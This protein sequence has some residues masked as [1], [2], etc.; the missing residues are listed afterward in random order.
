[1]LTQR[2][3]L[4]GAVLLL[5]LLAG[6]FV[7][8]LVNVLRDWS[9]AEPFPQTLLVLPSL[10]LIPLVGFVVQNNP[11]APLCCV[12]ILL[13]LRGYLPANGAPLVYSYLVA[14]FLHVILLFQL[15]DWPVL[16]TV[17]A[18]ASTALLFAAI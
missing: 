10:W 1:M 9:S 4:G 14:V 18:L 12:P 15:L 7:L 5:C 2:P 17:L 11:L 6:F 16:A 8:S 3:L 13:S